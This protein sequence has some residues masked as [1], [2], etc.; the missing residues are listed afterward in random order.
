[1]VDTQLAV[2][3]PSDNAQL[4]TSLVG[5]EVAFF[6]AA[7]ANVD[8][9]MAGGN[10]SNAERNA[11]IKVEELRLVHGL[12]LAA[13]FLRQK[14]LREIE[15]QGL[16]FEHP[17]RF[18]NMAELAREVGISVT[19]L[20]YENSLVSYIFP[21]FLEHGLQPAEIYERM[22]RSNLNDI[23]P[24][25]K[26]LIS[27]EASDRQTTNES[28][29]TMM[30]AASEGLIANARANNQPDPSDEVVRNQA[31]NNLVNNGQTMTNRDLRQTLRPTP[32]AHIEPV[33]VRRG[34]ERFVLIKMTDAQYE[35]FERKLGG[36][37]EPIFTSENPSTIALAREFMNQEHP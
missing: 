12:D 22:S 1:M 2:F 11:A 13:I 9:Q 31:V 20:S 3:A 30:S 33:I 14:L 8:A 28:A 7:Q 16:W 37:Q 32:T 4:S 19:Q 17:N 34:A 5:L 29:E 36:W 10:Y 25:L 15:E 27:G 6:N 35:T 21:Y 18:R 26:V 23:V 24:V